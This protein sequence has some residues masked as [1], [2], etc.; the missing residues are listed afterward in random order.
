MRLIAGKYGIEQDMVQNIALLLLRNNSVIFAIN[1][2]IFFLMIYY[3]ADLDFFFC[4][5]LIN[6]AQVSYSRTSSL[7]P[8]GP[9]F[10]IALLFSCP[11]ISIGLVFLIPEFFYRP[12]FRAPFVFIG[13]VFIALEIYRPTSSR[14]QIFFAVRYANIGLNSFATNYRPV[15]YRPVF[16]IAQFFIAQLFFWFFVNV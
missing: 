15:F 6:S 11:H 12:P 9:D 8:Y 16:F 14:V 5:R 3:C 1:Y 4:G 7:R 10:R 13:L 2:R